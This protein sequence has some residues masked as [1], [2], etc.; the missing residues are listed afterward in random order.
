MIVAV[1]MGTMARGPFVKI[2]NAVIHPMAIF[3][4]LD[5]RADTHSTL[6]TSINNI[7]NISLSAERTVC[8]E[9]TELGLVINKWFVEISTLQVIIPAAN[10]HQRY[11]T[12][13]ESSMIKKPLTALRSLA[14]TRGDMCVMRDIVATT[15]YHTGGFSKKGL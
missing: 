10:P 14:V 6:A 8:V 12:V 7:K 2:A 3:V 9:N 13:H 4:L 5:A 1:T 15:A 11:A